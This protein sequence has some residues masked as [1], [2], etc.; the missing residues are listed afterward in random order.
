[1]AAQTQ[2][3]GLYLRLSRDDEGAG[4]SASIA[5]QREILRRFA[6][7]EG[8]PVAAE[9]VDDGYSG[10]SFERPGFRL[11]LA[12]IERGEIDCV[13]VKDLSRLGRNSAR[14]AELLE[15]Y[16]PRRRVRFLS[17]SDG[18]DS[19]A[20]SNGMAAAAPF[21]LVLHEAYA[22]DISQK[23]RASF[24]AKMER[25]DFI[26]P[27]APYGYRKDPEN[28]NRLLVDEEAAGVVRSIFRMAADGSRPSDI[29]RTLNAQGVPTP[30]AY[31][32]LRDPGQHGA[33]SGHG[34]WTASMLCKLLRNEVYRGQTA[35]G[36]TAKLSFKSREMLPIP[37]GDWIT[38]EGTHEPLVPDALF[39]QVR[40]RTAA[41][42]C[43]PERGFRNLFSGLAFCADCGRG[44]T[45]ALSRRKGSAYDLCCG[46]YKA[47][48]AAACTNHFIG[49][50]ALCRIVR[51]ELQALLC[52]PEEE[53]QRLLNTLSRD[54]LTRGAAARAQQE[55]QL[56]DAEGRLRELDALS[57]RSF[58][59]AALGG[60]SAARCAALLADYEAERAGLERS[61][62][63]LRDA[64]AAERTAEGGDDLTTLLDE[65]QHGDSLD[66]DLL[67]R[68]IER[69]EVGQ[70]YYEPGPDGKRVRRQTVRIV[71]RVRGGT[72]P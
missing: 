63:Q 66:A 3:A 14:T 65:L 2:R 61:V 18:Y 48:G 24:R 10:T 15:E 30:A 19:A 67:H 22:R 47:R 59:L 69:V 5:T 42:R 55:R 36:K 49:Y 40:R 6:L 58:E 33:D 62:R 31:R 41:R 4:E 13:M 26:G 11:L 68:L 25:G 27:R 1:M 50:D 39:D 72:A 35:Q 71:F 8:I 46:N 56:R 53:R 28:K 7:R 51:E 37:R 45:S 16:F 23:I 32:R 52:L 29:A 70:G 60:A 57:R 21:M 38:V 43:A 34:L 54:A 44:M 20:L 17:V 64:L 12:A 9:F